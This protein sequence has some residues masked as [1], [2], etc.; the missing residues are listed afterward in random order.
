MH[1]PKK[2]I[3]V[4]GTLKHNLKPELIAI[5]RQRC[6][7]IP[8]NEER[9]DTANFCFRHNQLPLLKAKT[10]KLRGANQRAS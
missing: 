4:S 9:R 5:K 10:T 1:N 2:D 8:H 6:R 3:V 7:D